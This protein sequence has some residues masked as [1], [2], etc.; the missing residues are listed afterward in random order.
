[1]TAEQLK[2]EAVKKREAAMEHDIRSE[3]FHILINE[4]TRLEQKAYL[5]NKT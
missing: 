5:L 2:A 1:M 4:A 3:E